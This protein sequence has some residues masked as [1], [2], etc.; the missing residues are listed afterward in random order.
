M[1]KKRR[2]RD[3]IAK[4]LFLMTTSIFL[5]IT[6]FNVL[7]QWMFF[8]G[9]YN[10]RK[11]ETLE[12]QVQSFKSE[13]EDEY[14]EVDLMQMMREYQ[15]KYSV[16]IAV[17]DK[18]GSCTMLSTQVPRVDNERLQLV[19]NIVMW[20]QNDPVGN[21]F[22]KESRD[23]K[24]ELNTLAYV[25]TGENNEYIIGITSLEQVSEA[26]EISL[27]MNFYFAII[28]VV[29]L[30][31]ISVLYSNTISKPL[32]KINRVAKKIAKLDFKE[33]C[34]VDRN[35][36]IG[37]LSKSINVM[38]TNLEETLTSLREANMKL[39]EDIEKERQLEKMRKEFIA[40]VSH[41]LKTPIALIK[42]YAEGIQ[43]EILDKEDAVKII[44]DESDK[45]TK[46]V[47]DMINLSQLENGTFKMKKERFNLSEIIEVVTDK[48]KALC[49]DRKINVKV[50]IDEDL[51]VYG[52]NVR[53]EQVLLNYLS[54]G[55]RH[56]YDEGEIIVTAT[57]SGDDVLV[58][59][60][61]TGDHIDDD[62][63]DKIWEKFYKIDK[64]RKRDGST[65]LGLSITKNIIN[66]H[67]GNVAVVNTEKGVK[68]SFTIPYSKK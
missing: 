58:E 2:I 61:N 7:I 46:L 19:R 4:R 54:N 12:K 1:R 57:R 59:V 34:V 22:I 36:E 13:Y 31:F 39:Q 55:I 15:Q 50:N 52:D 23:S 49:Y 33:K 40:D 68:F 62:E 26:S 45:M 41:E 21:R 64:G 28:S 20:F 66:V 32:V 56:C 10:Y 63:I 67:G 51:Y 44:I 47:M 8:E 53:L 5:G 30:T 25:T 24:Y 60:E 9:Y 11:K 14:T 27:Q 37:S 38:S 65:G 43:D 35:D 17:V 29:I 3:S 16:T 6:I 18:A 48:S 42:G